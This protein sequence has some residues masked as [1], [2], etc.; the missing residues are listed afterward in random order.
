MNERAT[1]ELIIAEKLEQLRAPEMIDAIWARIETRLDLDMPTDDGGGSTNPPASPVRPGKWLNTGF[2]IAA[3]ALLIT[4][5]F[6]NNNKTTSSPSTTPAITSPQQTPPTEEEV[7]NHSPGN[8]STNNPDRPTN[9]A[10]VPLSNTNA[11]TLSNISPV[12]NNPETRD[13][14]ALVV[15]AEKNNPIFSPPVNNRVD[16][17]KKQRGVKGINENDY[18]I[19]P[20]KDTVKKNG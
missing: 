12:I 14:S 17:V 16:S 5:Y 9:A 3:V 8:S 2:M 7:N 10:T 1:Y 19:V 11:D 18:R 6:Y 15:P 4:F 20:K 13:T